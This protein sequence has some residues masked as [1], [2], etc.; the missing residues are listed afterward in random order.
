MRGNS[1][2]LHTNGDITIYGAVI[3]HSRVCK[4]EGYIEVTG[5]ARIDISPQNHI[6]GAKLQ[7]NYKNGSATKV[8]VNGKQEYP[9]LPVIPCKKGHIRGH[10]A[11]IGPIPTT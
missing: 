5:Y 8:F 11:R 4:E 2:S 7:V 9:S 1:A 6:I 3:I 10:T